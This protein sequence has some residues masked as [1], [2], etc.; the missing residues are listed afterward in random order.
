MPRLRRTSAPLL[1]ACFGLWMAGRLRPDSGP[2]LVLVLAMLV[3][4]VAAAA[5]YTVIA[6]GPRAT[7]RLLVTRRRSTLR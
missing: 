7:L 4:A 6:D 5:V 3:S 1:A 2:A